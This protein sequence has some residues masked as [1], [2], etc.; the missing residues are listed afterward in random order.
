M[1]DSQTAENLPQIGRD[2]RLPAFTSRRSRLQTHLK[3][4]GPVWLVAGLT[5]ANGVFSLAQMLLVRFH[6]SPRL[7]GEVLPFGVHHW[8]RTL[9]VLFG[10]TLIYLSLNLFERRR[11]AWAVTIVVSLL[12][13]LAHLGRG[14]DT[15]HV[16]SLAP[17]F[18]A[19]LLFVSR[20]RFTVPPYPEYSDTKYLCTKYIGIQRVRQEKSE[21]LA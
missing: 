5:L 13:T 10:F 14:D 2:V 11:V 16:L 3:E 6:P 21:P 19:V 1:V 8:N 12:S 18:T 15:S 4:Q 9:T 20:S 7:L 17:A